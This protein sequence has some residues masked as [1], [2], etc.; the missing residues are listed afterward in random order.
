MFS[1]I[2]AVLCVITKTYQ[3]FYEIVCLRVKWML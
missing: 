2:V 3:W 1:I